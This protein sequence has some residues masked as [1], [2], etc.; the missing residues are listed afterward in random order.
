MRI[1]QPIPETASLVAT[2]DAFQV[3]GELGSN[4]I[5]SPAEWKGSFDQLGG[6]LSVDTGSRRPRELVQLDEALEKCLGIVIRNLF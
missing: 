6:V 5:D 1:H 3:G 2:P 4:M